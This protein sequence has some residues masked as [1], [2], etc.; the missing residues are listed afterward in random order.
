MVFR[1]LAPEF[2]RPRR[3]RPVMGCVRARTACTPM[4]VVMDTYKV[5]QPACVDKG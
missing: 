1:M 3:L 2:H 5:G 4:E